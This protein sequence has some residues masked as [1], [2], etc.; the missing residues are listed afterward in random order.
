MHENE[1]PRPVVALPMAKSFNDVVSMDLKYWKKNFYF[2]VMVDAATRFCAA[3]TI[4]NKIPSNIIQCIFRTWIS[5][6]GALKKFLM[7]NGREFSNNEMIGLGEKFNIRI[8][9]IAAYS[10]F[11]SG[12]CERTNGIF[13]GFS[14]YQLVFGFNTNYP[15]LDVYILPTMEPTTKSE[16]VRRNLS[17]LNSARCE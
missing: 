16:T 8:M 11:S 4:S 5:K 17:A 15:S 9:N 7:D 12:L 3:C 2:M 13:G 1:E 10:P 6:F 14:L